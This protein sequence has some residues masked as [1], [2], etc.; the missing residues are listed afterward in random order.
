MYICI[1][2][3]GWLIICAVYCVAVYYRLQHS[4]S[5]M[6]WLICMYDVTHLHVRHVWIPVCAT[7]RVCYVARV[8]S[9]IRARHLTH[10]IN[11]SCRTLIQM[12]D[13]TCHVAERTRHV[14]HMNR[15]DWLI[16]ATWPV[17]M[18]DMTDSYVW[19]DVFTRAI[20]LIHMCDM[21]LSY[22]RH[23]S[24]TCATWLIDMC[25]TI[26]LHV[27]HSVFICVTE[28]VH[29]D[30]FACA[31]S[32]LWMRA[33]WCIHMCNMMPSPIILHMWMHDAFTCA[34]W[35]VTC[36]QYDA[37]TCA[38]WCL[39]PCDMTLSYVRTPYLHVSRLY[40]L[41]DSFVY[42]T[43][44][45]CLCDM[46]HLSMWHDSFVYVTWRFHMYDTPDLLSFICLI[47]VCYM[48]C[49]TYKSTWYVLYVIICA[50]CH[51]IC[52]IYMC[53]MSCRYIYM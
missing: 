7:W 35:H 18:C 13:M 22:L 6:L 5:H 52:L 9:R 47:Y 30:I 19:R 39:H 20:W 45:I 42:V 17:H 8:I 32:I 46:T 36:V 11:E 24:C 21:S 37:F 53:Y 10:R 38:I 48:S 31:I 40:V 28:R 1:C 50:I 41:H 15:H 16:C 2:T 29:H 4:V 23:A 26:L 43:W 49:S 33:R 14:A 25:D 34:I 27:R 44:L 12:C 51:V 3:Y